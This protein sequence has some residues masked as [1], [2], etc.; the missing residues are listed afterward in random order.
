M[1]F[2]KY[3]VSKTHEN[4]KMLDFFFCYKFHSACPFAFVLR[5]LFRTYHITTSTFLRDKMD[6]M[7][8]CF[9]GEGGGTAIVI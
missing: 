7:D 1:Y 3:L 5:V 4:K 2:E 6:S 8:K 9:F